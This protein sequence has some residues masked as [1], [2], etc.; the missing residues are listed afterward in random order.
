M[1]GSEKALKKISQIYSTTIA[2]ESWRIVLDNGWLWTR[3]PGHRYLLDSAWDDPIDNDDDFDVHNDYED[4]DM[5]NT[6][7]VMIKMMFTVRESRFLQLTIKQSIL[8]TWWD[9]K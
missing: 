8:H 5:M 1:C 3:D 2:P 6:M 4:V 9:E 7:K